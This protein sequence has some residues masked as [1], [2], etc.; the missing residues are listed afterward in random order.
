MRLH[1]FETQLTRR[2]RRYLHR[3]VLNAKL[4]IFCVLLLL[5]QRGERL[6]A[7]TFQFGNLFGVRRTLVRDHL[8]GL[9]AIRQFSLDGFCFGRYRR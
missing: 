2:G 6:V 4:G 5:L 1:F 8:E 7:Q 3:E 9:F